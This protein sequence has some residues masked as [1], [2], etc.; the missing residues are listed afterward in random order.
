MKLIFDTLT[1]DTQAI[2]L[3]VFIATAGAM[4]CSVFALG[5]TLT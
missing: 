3:A 4:L 5:V 1:A 2:E